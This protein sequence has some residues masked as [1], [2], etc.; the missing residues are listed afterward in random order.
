MALVCPLTM[1]T[2]SSEASRLLD[3]HDL[4]DY[5]GRPWRS[6]ERQLINPPPGFPSPIRLG[7][8]VFWS[9]ELVDAWLRGQPVA[10]GVRITVPATDQP[11]PKRGRGRPRRQPTRVEG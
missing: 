5:L 9:R 6:L 7:R 1:Q 4:G 8:R 3:M 10:E 11:Q 2:N